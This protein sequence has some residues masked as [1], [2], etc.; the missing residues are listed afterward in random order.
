M[1]CPSSNGPIQVRTDLPARDLLAHAGRLT[2]IF[3]QTLGHR[4]RDTLIEAFADSRYAAFA[5]RGGALVGAGRVLSDGLYYGLLV[6]VVVDPACQRMGVGRMLVEGLIGA[7]QGRCLI[8]QSTPE[9]RGFYDAIG[10]Q[11]MNTGIIHYTDP[12]AAEFARRNG[13]V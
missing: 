3:T 1:D 9:A 12:E 5:F 8:A 2:R 13:Y 7:F 4:D 6:D 11:A 10:F